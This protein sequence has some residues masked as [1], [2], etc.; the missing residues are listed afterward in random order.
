MAKFREKKEFSFNA[1]LFYSLV[2][3]VILFHGSWV[4]SQKIS[5][6]LQNL[7]TVGSILNH[8]KIPP[9]VRFNF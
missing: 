8:C 3:Y 5:I 2:F 6:L 4:F 1:R 7:K 9:L